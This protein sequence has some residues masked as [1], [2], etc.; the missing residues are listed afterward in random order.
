[1][2]CRLSVLLL[3]LLST[4]FYCAAEKS[5]L[6]GDLLQWAVRYE[7][8]RGVK[9]D[10]QKAFQLYCMAADQGESEAYYA[11]G[12]MVFNHRGVDQDRAV[13]AGWFKKAAAAG[14]PAA[15]RMQTVLAGIEPRPDPN[16]GTLR[17][18]NPNRQQIERWVE[19]WAPA[20][21]LDADLVLAVILAESNFNP[22]AH[23]QQD[24]RGL[25]QLIPA[26]A[27]RFGVRDIWDPS[28][29]MHGGM[30]YLQWLVKRFEGDVPLVLAAY[31]AGE[32]AVES[33][34]GV[35]PYRETRHYVKRITQNYLKPV[36]PVLGDPL[37][38][39]ISY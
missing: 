6:A 18:D 23:S 9:Q 33:Y 39:L 20:Y 19:R 1:M 21:G 31:N 36:H 29:N 2:S 3:L 7:H 15:R 37:I 5:P 12:W 26:T 13:A 38:S 11:L 35:P 10:Y 34:H 28:Q 25:M 27:K 32:R 24:A 30:A 4:P 8:G 17:R 14:D 22:R 16:C